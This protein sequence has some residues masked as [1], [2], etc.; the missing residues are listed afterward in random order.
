MFCFTIIVSLFAT[1]KSWSSRLRQYLF[2]DR[3]SERAGEAVKSSLVM[4]AKLVVL[5]SQQMEDGGM[6]IPE[7]NL[8]LHRAG[9]GVVGLAMGNARLYATTGQPG[10][11]P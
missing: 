9:S 2:H 10:G 3:S 6:K 8:S 7:V 11:E 5:Q 4:K 1:A